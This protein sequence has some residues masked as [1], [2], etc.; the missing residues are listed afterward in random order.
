MYTNFAADKRKEVPQ[1]RFA[2]CVPIDSGWNCTPQIGRLMCRSAITTPSA[3]HAIFLNSGGN[4][5]PT[6]SD[7]ESQ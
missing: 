6:M 5:S 3:V 4:G 2:Y 7:N 1:K